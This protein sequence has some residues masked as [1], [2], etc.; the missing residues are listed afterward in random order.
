MSL[1]GSFSLG[2][3][4]GGSLF[5]AGMVIAGGCGAGSIWRAGEGQVKWRCGICSRPGMNNAGAPA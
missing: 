5:G 4:L 1:F 3:L 2:A